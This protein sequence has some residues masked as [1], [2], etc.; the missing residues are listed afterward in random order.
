M[1][2]EGAKQEVSTIPRRKRLNV[3]LA[4]AVMVALLVRKSSYQ[5]AAKQE[6]AAI[7]GRER[8]WYVGRHSNRTH[9]L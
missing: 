4:I 5:P 6:P 9:N 8:R 2:V 3:L 1:R 7:G